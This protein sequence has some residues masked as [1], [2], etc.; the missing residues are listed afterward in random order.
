MIWRTLGRL[1]LIPIATLLAA[2]AALAV[3]V[4]LGLERFT[5]ATYGRELDPENLSKIVDW[6]MTGLQWASVMAVL[7]A[8]A[9]VLIGE[10]AR[11]RS[12]LYYVIGGGVALASIPLFTALNQGVVAAVPLAALWQVLA[13]AGFAGGFVYWLVAGRN[14]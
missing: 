2:M 4:T 6:V 13:T 10:V 12:W 5:H 14:A 11:I 7:P 9:V 3:L 1:I 8:L